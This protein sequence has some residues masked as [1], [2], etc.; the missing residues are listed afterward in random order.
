VG[1]ARVVFRLAGF[2]LAS[3]ST[4]GLLLVTGCQVADEDS[5]DLLG[6]LVNHQRQHQHDQGTQ[7]HG[8]NSKDFFR[9]VGGW[10]C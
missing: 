6:L 10:G 3:Q 8:N 4:G 5:V 7:P 1:K 9:D 2:K